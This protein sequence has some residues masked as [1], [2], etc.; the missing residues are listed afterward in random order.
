[1][2]V[3][4]FVLVTVGDIR[5]GHSQG[6]GDGSGEVVQSRDG[7][8]VSA[9]SPWT[10]TDH[11][12]DGT[13]QLRFVENGG[14][15]LRSRVVNSGFDCS[16]NLK[17]VDSCVDQCG[18]TCAFESIKRA[19]QNKRHSRL[20]TSK[21]ELL[22][23]D[24]KKNSKHTNVKYLKEVMASLNKSHYE[25]AAESK[26]LLVYD[27]HTQKGALLR[28]GGYTTQES[29]HGL[30]LK[31]DDSSRPLA[32]LSDVKV[33]I[34]NVPAGDASLTL[35]T[36]FGTLNQFWYI[37]DK[38]IDQVDSRFYVLTVKTKTSNRKPTKRKV[39][40][41]MWSMAGYEYYHDYVLTIAVPPLTDKQCI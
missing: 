40:H 1:M 41:G 31:C 39:S 29:M 17:K 28:V 15:S 24:C 30:L 25:L 33:E 5:S 38:L 32:L 8:S 12:V 4:L 26:L 35:R 37:P 21:L 36:A 19:K 22:T 16:A 6:I 11:A 10:K 23:N 18:V 7:Q 34:V 2:R 20:K 3:L 27:T 13:G 14:Q 9:S